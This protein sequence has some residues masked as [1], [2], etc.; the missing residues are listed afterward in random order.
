[1]GHCRI[2]GVTGS[3]SITKLTPADVPNGIDPNESP[4]FEIAIAGGSTSE[5]DRLRDVE[6]I[7]FGDGEQ[8]FLIEGE[9]KVGDANMLVD[10]GDGIDVADFS[11]LADGIKTHLE[12]IDDKEYVVSDLGV[13]FRNV[14]SLLAAKETIS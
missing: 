6:N 14:R 11:N 8:R 2:P 13:G 10:G 9:T 4:V 12:Q 7:R 5:I 1:V 3:I